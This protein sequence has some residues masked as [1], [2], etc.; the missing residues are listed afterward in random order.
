MDEGGVM[1]VWGRR[2]SPR[3]PIECPLYEAIFIA[4]L[5][6]FVNTPKITRAMIVSGDHE[7]SGQE[8]QV[9]ERIANWAEAEL[10]K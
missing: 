5:H 2:F 8:A 9:A 6:K 10:L 1:Q 3:R 7:Y 4:S